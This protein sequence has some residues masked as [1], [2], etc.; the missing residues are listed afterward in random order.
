M[1]LVAE[2]AQN[3]AP[4]RDWPHRPRY[5]G[6]SPRRGRK[7]GLGLTIISQRAAKIDKNVLFAVQHPDDPQSHKP[8]N[9]LKAILS[10]VEGLSEGMEDDIQR[11]PI[12][13]ALISRGD[14]NAP[15]RGGQAPG[16]E[17]W[18]GER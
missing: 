4:S 11:L 9:D 6:P 7:F 1:M 5:S 13:V 2:E 14:L 15:I 18:R 10:S 3:G 17:A 12:G 16:V 8:K